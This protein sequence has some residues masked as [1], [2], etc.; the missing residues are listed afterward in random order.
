MN[1]KK[2]LTIS[3]T[4]TTRV[5]PS[6]A[7]NVDRSAL[8]G[9]AAQY[10][11]RG[12]QL[13][14]SK[15]VD[16]KA[17]ASVLAGIGSAI[18]KEQEESGFVSAPPPQMVEL[19]S[20]SRVYLDKGYMPLQIPFVDGAYLPGL[21]PDNSNSSEGTDITKKVYNHIKFPDQ[22]QRVRTMNDP[23]DQKISGKFLSPSTLRGNSQINTYGLAKN[24]TRALIK[25]SLINKMMKEGLH[26]KYNVLKAKLEQEYIHDDSLVCVFSFEP[27][28]TVAQ[29]IEDRG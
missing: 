5:R 18:G 16:N 20:G 3:E 13:P 7:S 15:G 17:V 6:N 21:H 8:Y 1:F 23:S 29:D 22:D 19:P 2:W 4:G 28:K 12:T 26:E 9:L 24:F 10:G 11:H 25:I 27:I 14:I